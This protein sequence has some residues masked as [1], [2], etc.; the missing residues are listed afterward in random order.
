LSELVN[1]SIKYDM[2]GLTAQK[3]PD[4]AEQAPKPAE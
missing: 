4:E 1:S 2:K 3:K